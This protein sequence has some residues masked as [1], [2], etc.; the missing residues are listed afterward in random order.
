LS[1]LV[2]SVCI[3]L[4]D[5]ITDGIVLSRLLRGRI[6]VP[7]EGYTPAY[8]VILCFGVVT[9]ALSL[10]Y[11]LRNAHMFRVQVLEMGQHAK[12]RGQTASFTQ[13][14]ESAATVFP[15]NPPDCKVSR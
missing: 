4:A 9:T 15:A 1:E 7:I 13:D 6:S 5:V 12:S 2:G 11:R 8:T 3:G 14:A 10:A